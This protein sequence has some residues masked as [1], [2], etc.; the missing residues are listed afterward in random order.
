M[1][2]T[3][4]TMILSSFT[5][6]TLSIVLMGV[7]VFLAGEPKQASTAKPNVLF[8]LADDMGWG[9]LS[10]HG[11]PQYKTP[12]LDRLA[13]QGIDV[14][15]FYVAAPICS[16]SRAGFL[17]G[18][19]PM[20]Y[21]I[22]MPY[23]LDVNIKENQPDWLDPRAPS[24][25]RL[26]QGAGYH[27]GIIGKWHL[28]EEFQGRMV[29]A[30]TPAAYGFN[31]WQLMRGPWAP[32]L[33]KD[34]NHQVYQ[35]AVDFLR[36]NRQRPF[37]LTVTMHETHVPYLPSKSALQAVTDL[38]EMQRKYAASV[39]DADR[40]I[41]RILDALREHSLEQNTLVLFSSDNGPARRKDDPEDPHGE[42]FNAGAT[43]GRR[44]WKGE[45]YEGGIHQPFIARWPGHIP[46]GKVD[47]VN[48]L[49][50]VDFLPTVCAA[51][52]VA[53][54]AD[55]KGDGE[56]RLPVLTGKVLPRTT[57]LFWYAAGQYAVRD[58][59]WKLVTGKNGKPAELFDIVADP[60]ES[61]DLAAKHQEIVRKL[62]EMLR[63]WHAA[64]PTSP[65][66]A[67]LSKSR[68]VKK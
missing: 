23:A 53:L 46:A 19:S 32:A 33:D 47:T 63:D 18:Q 37:Y 54:P 10:C 15:Q 16:P 2:N 5:H 40:G 58:Q 38:P 64:L 49:A 45:V 25:A 22:R 27:T 6:P 20:R 61:Q 56:N 13:S 26:L 50:G 41:G 24:V 52:G 48:V 60:G 7:S 8:I 66:P 21:G 3:L 57:P 9:D 36:D 30:P 39:I 35:A 11:H 34:F 62:E 43:G 1:V 29:D 55:Y 44:G 31:E 4:N 51:V 12:N 14:Q 65:V 42:R 28:V 68:V 59:H 67:C 17:T